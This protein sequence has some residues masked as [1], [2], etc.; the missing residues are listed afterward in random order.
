MV[1]RH[2]TKKSHFSKFLSDLEAEV[3]LN[4]K[5]C[6]SVMHLILYKINESKVAFVYIYT[7]RK[8]L[9]KTSFIPNFCLCTVS[10]KIK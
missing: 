5:T 7:P 6:K 10:K 9:L 2:L 3:P 1:D 8:K 4:F